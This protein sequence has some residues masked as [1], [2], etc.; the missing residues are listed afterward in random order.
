MGV[1]RCRNLEDT[2]ATLGA[3]DGKGWGEDKAYSEIF[4]SAYND[5]LL[6]QAG[7]Q[8]GAV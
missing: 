3:A 8:R 7:S 2:F 5:S 4:K 1:T 6:G